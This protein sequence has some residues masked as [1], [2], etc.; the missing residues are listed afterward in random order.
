LLEASHDGILNDQPILDK[1][2][3]G[4]RALLTHVDHARKPLWARV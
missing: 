3:F 1:L 4:K 2:N